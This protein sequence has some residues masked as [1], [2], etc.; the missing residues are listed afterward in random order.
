MTECIET[1][2]CRV[3]AKSPGSSVAGN[4]S[5]IVAIKTEKLT[6]AVR[7]A[8]DA[9]ELMEYYQAGLFETH[10]NATEARRSMMFAIMGDFEKSLADV[11]RNEDV[12][13]SPEKDWITKA[14]FQRTLLAEDSEAEWPCLLPYYW[15]GQVDDDSTRERLFQFIKSFRVKQNMQKKVSA[16]MFNSNFRLNSLPLPLDS[17]T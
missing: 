16:C 6:T 5:N 14:G 9:S 13:R 4:L 8:E 1:I 15:S 7:D 17:C 3:R 12:S 2:D 10:Q 11:M